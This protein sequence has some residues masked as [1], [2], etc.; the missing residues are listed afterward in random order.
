MTPSIKTVYKEKSFLSDWSTA[1]NSDFLASGSSIS[2]CYKGLN[3]PAL[4]T[5][6]D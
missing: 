5:C 2:T 3:S 6:S 1:A 4:L